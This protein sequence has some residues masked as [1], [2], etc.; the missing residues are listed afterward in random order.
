MVP[1]D[2]LVGARSSAGGAGVAQLVQ[3]VQNVQAVEDV[4]RIRI[5]RF[6]LLERIERFEQPFKELKMRTEKVNFY[7]EGIKLAGFFVSF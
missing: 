1:T 2:R 7:S 5:G 3:V 4:I 6:E